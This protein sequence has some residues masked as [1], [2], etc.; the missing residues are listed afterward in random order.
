MLCKRKI[1]RKNV[2]HLIRNSFFLLLAVIAFSCNNSEQYAKENVISL[3]D[4]SKHHTLIK[5]T[6]IFGIPS[7]SFNIIT[8]HIK[9]NR[10]L[11]EILIGYQL[12]TQEIDKVIKNSSKI[13]DVRDIRSGHNYTILCDKNSITRVRYFIYEHDPSQFYIFSFND[14]LNISKYVKETRSVIR[15]NSGTIETSL[16]D[17]ILGQ[18]LNPELVDKLSDIYAWTVDFFGLKKGDSFK[19]IYEEKL[20]DDKTAGVGRIYGAEF[21]HSGSKISAIPIIQNG[22]ESYYDNSGRSLRRSFLKAPLRFSRVSSRFSSGK[23][24]P[25][26]RIVRPHFGIDYA[27]PIGTPVYSVGDGKVTFAGIE[28]ESGGMV[29]IQHNSIYSTAY[30]HL[31]NFGNGIEPGSNVKQGEIIGY[32]GSS[33]LSTGPHLDFRFYKSG[34]AIDP[35]KVDASSVDSVFAGNKAKFEKIKSVVL[36]LLD[37]FD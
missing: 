4:S 13:F 29:R 15:F 28:N 6:L 8:G 14:S 27:A 33:G 31:G 9:P 22:K 16:W 11:S 26:L 12:S 36:T 30:L 20:I 23:M 17:A 2:Y 32:V 24:H 34:Y 25:I 35:F 18:R 5:P 37:T 7:D 10:F 3:T 1:F 19:V 21:D